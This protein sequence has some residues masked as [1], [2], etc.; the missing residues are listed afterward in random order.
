MF[1]RPQTS[2]SFCAVV[3]SEMKWNK[4]K[5]GKQNQVNSWLAFD[6]LTRNIQDAA[7]KI[8]KNI[9]PVANVFSP[10]KSTE[11]WIYCKDQANRF[12]KP[13]M[14]MYLITEQDSSN[15]SQNFFLRF[16]SQ[17]LSHMSSFSN[18]TTFYYLKLASHAAVLDWSGLNNPLSAI[19]DIPTGDAPYS[20]M[21][22]YSKSSC[23]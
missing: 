21:T 1:R 17:T 18:S 3:R 11:R 13:T 16:L 23:K 22:L 15:F 2:P 10:F 4:M 20:S 19:I 7:V 12:F 14:T 8:S 6:S 5:K 9:P